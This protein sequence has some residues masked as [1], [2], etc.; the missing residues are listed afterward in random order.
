MVQNTPIDPTQSIKV[1]PTPPQVVITTQNEKRI[2]PTSNCLS[3]GG[4]IEEINFY[5]PTLET[6]FFYKIYLP[7]CYGSSTD[8]Y[9][10]VLYLLH[11]LSYDNQQWIH[12]GLANQL[13]AMI[14]SGQVSQLIVVLPLEARFDP[15]ES[16]LFGDV[17]AKELLPHVD[18]NFR[19]LS[20]KTYRAI[21][22]LSRGAAWSVRIGFEHYEIFSKVGAHSLPLFKFDVGHIQT[23]LTE[24]PEE[25]LPLF[26]IDI[27]RDD[28]EWQSAQSFANQL[29]QNA[30]PHE[31]YLFNNGHSESYW[32]AHLTQYLRWYARD[33]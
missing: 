9:Y 14:Q 4:S 18:A 21:G 5:S 15:P 20:E 30:V 13:D 32:S 24:I 8:Q 29:D 1:S 3:A 17:V 6:D 10:P 7:P 22:G 33:W 25:D 16:A 26:Y 23:W 27:G 12:L 28:P 11:G 19:S 2:T 31:W